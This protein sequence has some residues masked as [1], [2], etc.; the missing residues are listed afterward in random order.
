MIKSILD[1]AIGAKQTVL[2]TL[3]SLWLCERA[4]STV[5][6]ERDTHRIHT[7]FFEPLVDYFCKQTEFV[8]QYQALKSLVCYLR[9]INLVE[10]YP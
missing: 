2:V 10:F 8:L 1:G 5:E 7:D 3:R 4:S 6:P 9:K